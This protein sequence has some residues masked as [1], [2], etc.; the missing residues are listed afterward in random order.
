MIKPKENPKTI[1]ERSEAVIIA[2]LLLRGEVVLQPFGDNQRYDLVIDRNGTFV[3]VQCKTGRL[4]D[5]II[6]FYSSSNA[7]GYSK[8][9]YYGEV[10]MF[11]VYCPE[12]DRVYLVPIEDAASVVTTL[13]VD[14]PKDCRS[15]E[16][17]RWAK[18]YLLD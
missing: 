12:N 11:A 3:R 6:K 9:S 14:P 18:D 5:G 10:E 2:K 8:R 4:V 15:S 17:L 16:S 1:G 7:G 13:R